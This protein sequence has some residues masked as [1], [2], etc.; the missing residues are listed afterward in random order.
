MTTVCQNKAPYNKMALFHFPCH[1][2]F[3]E[4]MPHLSFPTYALLPCDRSSA[5]SDIM[6]SVLAPFLYLRAAN[7]NFPL[8]VNAEKSKTQ[9]IKLVN[10]EV[11]RNI[12]HH[13]TVA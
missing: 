6:Y 1:F 9:K 10:M 13:S 12:G 8:S 3:P 11:Q 2:S 5:S 4:K 7:R